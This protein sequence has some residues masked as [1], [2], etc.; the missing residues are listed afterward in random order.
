[1][2]LLLIGILIIIIFVLGVIL[3]HKSAQVSSLKNQ[4][5]FLEYSYEQLTEKKRPPNKIR[6]KACPILIYP[7]TRES[8]MVCIHEPISH[9]EVEPD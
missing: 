7:T 6:K 3:I 1:M 2:V 4:I 8:P 5:A 9:K